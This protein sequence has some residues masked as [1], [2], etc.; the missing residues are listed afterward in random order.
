M[1]AAPSFE[2]AQAYLLGTIN[3]ALSRKTSYTLDRMRALLRELGDPHRSY[4]TIHVGGTSGK[5]STSTMIASV[6]QA[7]GKR[8]GLHTKPHLQSMTERARIDGMPVSPERFAA[9]LEGMMPAIERVTA[10]YGRPTY[11]ETLLAIAFAHFAAER[12]DAAVIEVG[13]GGRL[14]GSNLLAPVVTAITSVGYDHTEVLGDTL[15][16]I[17]REKAGIARA[18]VPFVVAATAPVALRTLTECAADAGALLVRV[19][20]VVAIASTAPSGAYA[21]A[22]DAMTAR[23]R[24]AVNLPVH[25]LF[26][27]ANAAT[28]IAVLERLGDAL[29]PDP[30]SIECGLARV[31]I[32]GRME[33]FSG[34]PP[35]VFD[36]AHNAEKAEYLVASLR[37]TFPQ[38]RFHY[39]VAIGE[40]K[41]ARRIL[42]TLAM[43]PATFA[44][45]S[46]FAAGRPAI[47]PQRLRAIAQSLG[48]G[49]R[50]IA[51]PTEALAAARR[52]AAC[53]DVVVVTGSTFVVAAL[54]QWWLAEVATGEPS[55]C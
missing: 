4:P 45:T 32:P 55:A 18:G 21:Q 13:L 41:D 26:Q 24:Y 29:R 1:S 23:A 15:E 25:G 9:L 47:A 52:G 51:D 31:E 33:V 17:A 40:S 22:F 28:A 7:S 19:S 48:S 34:D 54:R 42:A 35:V 44:F 53:D 14:D 12:V 8:T 38:K 11:Y 20:D 6:L 10:A 50:A 43:L 46:F 16:A 39:V 2:R 5:G 27:I 3:E 37:N 36:I 30:R 49:G